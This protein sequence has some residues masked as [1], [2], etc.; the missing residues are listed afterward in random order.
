MKRVIITLIVMAA[1]YFGV[2]YF[3]GDMYGEKLEFN[4]GELYFT[5]KVTKDEANKL[6]NFLIE[7][8][9]FDGNEKSVQLNKVGN[10]YQFRMV[11]KEGSDKDST[12]IGYAKL[13]ALLMSMQVF[14]NQ[15]VVVHFT[16]DG[17]KTIAEFEP[18]EE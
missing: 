5:E 16:D 17:F 2:N 11:V 12:I 9:F 10:V 14:D 8:K 4:K 15:K 3:L 13:F 1:V 6:G 7:N 18:N